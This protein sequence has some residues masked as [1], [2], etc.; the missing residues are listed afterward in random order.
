VVDWV[1]RWVKIELDR[2]NVAIANTIS[3]PNTNRT[4]HDRCDGIISVDVSIE[5]R[6]LFTIWKWLYPL[7]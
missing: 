7:S 1:N 5:S 2:Y 3:T 6:A 4:R